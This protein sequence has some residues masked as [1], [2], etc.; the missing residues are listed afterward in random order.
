[1]AAVKDVP[2]KYP[3]ASKQLYP[4]IEK[5]TGNARKM[6][7]SALNPIKQLFVTIDFFFIITP[8]KQSLVKQSI[9]HYL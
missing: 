2:F 1:M 4:D 5:T 6:I 7:T 3:N 8:F 9:Q